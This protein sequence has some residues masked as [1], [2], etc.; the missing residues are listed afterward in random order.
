VQAY[1]GCKR[2]LCVG[3]V[4]HKHLSEVRFQVLMAASMMFRAVSE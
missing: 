4:L 2:N 3:K 1:D